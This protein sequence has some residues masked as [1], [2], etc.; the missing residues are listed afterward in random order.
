MSF[1]EQT[2]TPCGW[3]GTLR[4]T[5]FECPH[6]SKV[7]AL[8]PGTTTFYPATIVQSWKKVRVRGTLK[9]G[10]RPCPLVLMC[11]LLARVFF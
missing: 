10:R 4:E 1:E 8:F 6:G 3:H 2:G 9:L 5:R 7:L 11:L